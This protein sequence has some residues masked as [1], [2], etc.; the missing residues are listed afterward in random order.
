MPPSPHLPQY[1]SSPPPAAPDAP[2]WEVLELA[3][4]SA[5]AH[6]TFQ[7]LMTEAHLEYLRVTET[8]LTGRLTTQPPPTEPATE[9]ATRPADGSPAQAAVPAQPDRQRSLTV[10]PPAGPARGPG[11]EDR[12]AVVPDPPV[13]AIAAVAA[14]PSP[15]RP[16]PT[17]EAGV[18]VRPAPSWV[19]TGLGG[20]P[21]PGLDA[22]P[23]H[24][25]DGGS[26]LAAAVAAELAGRGVAAVVSDG[27]GPGGVVLLNGMAGPA[28]PEDAIGTQLAGLRL[29]REGGRRGV[30]VIVAD[31]VGRPAGAWL[32]GLRGLATSAEP[33]RTP[34]YVECERGARG[35]AA[36]AVLIADE[37]TRGAGAQRVRLAADGTR[38]IGHPAE[39]EPSD[40]PGILLGPEHRIGADSVLLAHDCGVAVVDLARETRC[41]LIL[42]GNTP[43]NEEPPGLTDALDERAILRRFA[44]GTGGP[45]GLA[46]MRARARALLTVREIRATIEACEQAGAR[47][48]YLCVDTTEALSFALDR[49][50]A[51]WGPITGL[52][53]GP[54]LTPAAK[55]DVAAGTQLT[56][57]AAVLAA[58]A[59]DPLDTI[60]LF[61]GTADHPMVGAALDR[62][63][64]AEQEHRPGCLVRSLTWN[65]LR[66]AVEPA[67]ARPGTVAV[68]AARY[69]WIGDHRPQDVAILPPAAGLGWMAAAV[70]A[71]EPEAV[72]TGF[73]VLRPV[74]TG[75]PQTIS[76]TTSGREVSLVNGAGEPCYRARFGAPGRDREW[77][78]I[79]D[80]ARFAGSSVYAGR[81]LF[82]GPLLRS[83]HSLGEIGPAGVVGTVFGAG[84]LGWADDDLPVDLAALDGAVQLSGVWAMDEHRPVLP[85]G[86]AECRIHR[87]GRLPGPALCVVADGRRDDLGARCDA[88]LV[89]PDG[90]LWAELL[91]I[92]F[93]ALTAEAPALGAPD[94]ASRA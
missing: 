5:E 18:L 7:R 39:A 50:R 73:R 83:I 53:H 40:W 11:P 29:A 13:A 61:S 56:H 87:W 41:R 72:L 37:L 43:L 23:V 21:L 20:H 24:I 6:A 65:S 60:V 93:V 34:V 64:E 49:V 86:V 35:P 54:V 27:R 79:G 63:A 77:R 8:I 42:L 59:R 91:G 12:T 36:L 52:L 75:E 22:G 92:E 90:E 16:A 57:L 48:R 28:T 76:I 3:R 4:R 32:G 9:P 82:H 25:V 80:P 38:S 2:G 62:V 81:P 17:A 88:A 66:T 71:L 33:G 67:R 78:P 70:R 10:A 31:T 15:D 45:D 46:G 30:F 19:E 58:T 44:A 51:D 84:S 89:G 26:G 68:N 74:A 47:V 69:P 1:D 94:P 85:M 55:S 14:V